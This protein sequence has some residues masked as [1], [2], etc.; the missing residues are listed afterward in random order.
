MQNIERLLLNRGPTTNFPDCIKSPW[1]AFLLH[2]NLIND[3][4]SIKVG[5]GK[6]TSFWC[7][8]WL[9]IS[10]L[11]EVYPRLYSFHPKTILHS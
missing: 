11:K 2:M 10:P 4:V 9:R 3:R 1:C 6:N 7:N 8:H 5:N